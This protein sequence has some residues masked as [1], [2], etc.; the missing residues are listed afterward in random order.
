MIGIILDKGIGRPNFFQKIYAARDNNLLFVFQR[1]EQIAFISTFHTVYLP[2]Q[3]LL[4]ME[5]FAVYFQIIF[6]I[7]LSNQPSVNIWQ[8]Q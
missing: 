7:Y 8:R 6:S 4:L 1:L 2:E 3:Q 5:F